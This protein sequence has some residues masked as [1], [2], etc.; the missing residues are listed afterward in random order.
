MNSVTIGDTVIVHKDRF[1][2]VSHPSITILGNGEWVAAFN[3]SQR[4]VP[5]MHPPEDPL[6][7]TLLCRSADRGATWDDPTFAPNFD[8]YGTECP[9]IATLADGTVALSQRRGCVGSW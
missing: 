6:Y 4:R 3:H 9:G 5:P 8:W 7:R 2:Y 1:A